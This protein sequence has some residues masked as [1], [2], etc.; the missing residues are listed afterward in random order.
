MSNL[1]RN[2]GAITLV[3]RVLAASPENR[4]KA[5]RAFNKA[6]TLD[7]LC[8][9]AALALVDLYID[10]ADY[11]TCIELLQHCL[12]NHNQDFLHTKLADVFTLNE[13]YSEALTCYHTA[14]SLNPS[15]AAAAQ[16]LERLEKLMRGVDPDLEE[17]EAEVEEEEQAGEDSPYI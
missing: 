4:E 14:I 6:L 17:E 7:P 11:G 8:I 10:L 5:K 13:Q 1:P 3:G 9:D 2:P 12:Q 15:S 16:G